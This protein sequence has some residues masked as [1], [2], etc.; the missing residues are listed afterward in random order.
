MKHQ[1]LILGSLLLAASAWAQTGNSAISG[2]VRDATDAPLPGAH[3]AVLNDD[4][5]VRQ[6][7]VSNDAGVYRFATLVPGSYHL[8]ISADGF[9]KSL[10]GP[11]VIQVAQS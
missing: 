9:Q 8:E 6:E 1:L 5:G 4:S 2:V 11:I 10:R 3:V 7:T